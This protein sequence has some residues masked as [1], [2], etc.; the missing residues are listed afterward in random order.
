M[1]PIR[2]FM[3]WACALFPIGVM[4]SGDATAASSPVLA[5]DGARRLGVQCLVD[6]DPTPDRRRL[7]AALCERVRTL[8]ADKAPIPVVLLAPGDPGLIAADTAVLL[9]HANVQPGQ[10]Q[11]GPL[12][13]FSLRVFR[14]T[15][16]PSE[17]FG[18]APRATALPTGPT[19]PDRQFDAAVNAA[20]AETLPWR[21]RPT[22]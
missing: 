12:L 13:V 21:S 16:A 3:A 20:L 2:Q 15:A 8:A 6:P 19:Q 14:A 5:W 11:G 1:S 17:L 22:P 10:A 18:A 4:I 7:Q 9:F